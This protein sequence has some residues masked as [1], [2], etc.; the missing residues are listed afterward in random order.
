LISLNQKYE[1]LQKDY[2]D[3]KKRTEETNEILIR[4]RDSHPEFFESKTCYENNK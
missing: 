1:N 3:L 4:I 2:N